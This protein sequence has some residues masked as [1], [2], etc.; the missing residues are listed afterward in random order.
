MPKTAVAVVAKVTTTQK[1]TEVRPKA[2]QAYNPN[3][4]ADVYLKTNTGVIML[5]GRDGDETR[6]YIEGDKEHSPLDY[7]FFD[8]DK[9]RWAYW[10]VRD[11][12]NPIRPP[13]FPNPNQYSLTSLV[14]YTK[15]VTYTRVFAHAVGL[16][17][18]KPATLWDKML[19]PTTIIMAIVGIV[20]VMGLM[21]MALT[22]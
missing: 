9:K 8:D 21:L 6:E 15:A 1:P 12:D 10:A 22:G 4:V 19:K 13:T 17:K 14:L 16:L 11:G 7:R 18:E 2:K 5:I 3:M 20:F